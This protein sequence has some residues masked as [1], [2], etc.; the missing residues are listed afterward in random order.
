MLQG[1]LA[2][3]FGNL[4]SRCTTPAFLPDNLLPECG[5]LTTEDEEFIGS[6]NTLIGN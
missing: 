3:N 1:D 6:F 2:D 4:I 5:E